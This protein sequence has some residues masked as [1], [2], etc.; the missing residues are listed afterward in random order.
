V[1]GRGADPRPSA[2]T[3][4]ARRHVLPDGTAVTLRAIR[5]ADEPDL[6]ALYQRLSEKT[7]YQRFFT[8]MRRLPPDWARV[9]ARVD[10]DRTMAIV[11]TDDAG[12]L[13]AVARYAVGADGAAEIAI[14]VQDAW[15]NRGLGTL[16]LPELLAYGRE[17]G[18]ATF[19]AYVLAENARMLDLLGRVGRITGRTQEAGVVVVRMAPGPPPAAPGAAGPSAGPG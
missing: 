13:V 3:Y 6:T 17:R 14:V 18:I 10:Y 7:A 2:E 4:G 9:L 12:Q 1:T 16:M 11:A 15:Q 5:S 8:V 19:R